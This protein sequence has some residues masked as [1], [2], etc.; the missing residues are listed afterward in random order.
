ML[1]VAA[2][3]TLF[4]GQAQA[5]C[6][7][8]TEQAAAKVRNLQTRLMDATFKCQLIHADITPAYNHFIRT[9]RETLQGANAVL[10]SRLGERDYDRFVTF[11]ANDSSE[12]AI[13]ADHCALAGELAGAGAVAAGSVQALVALAERH[14]LEPEL[15]GGACELTFASVAASIAPDSGR[16]APSVEWTAD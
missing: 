10:R 16:A 13:D 4:T 8:P 5:A 12:Q 3:L 9:N 14:R 6:W 2:A 1:G 7:S 15:D 11:L